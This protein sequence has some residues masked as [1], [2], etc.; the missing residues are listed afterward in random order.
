MEEYMKMSLL[1][2][3][4]LLKIYLNYNSVNDNND[5]FIAY[6]PIPEKKDEEDIEEMTSTAL[7]L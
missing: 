2:G 1:K 5:N 3:Q 6:R 7:L 4:I